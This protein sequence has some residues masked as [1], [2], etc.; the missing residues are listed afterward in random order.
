MSTVSRIAI[1]LFCLSVF[2]AAM[3]DTESEITAA[4]D[5]YAEMWNDGDIEALRGYYDPDFVLLT[6]TGTL[7]LQQRLDD[8]EA[9]AAGGKDRGEMSH[10]G[11][12]VS[13]LG[14]NHAMAYGQVRLAFKDGSS[15]EN[16]FSTVY[17][18]TP[19]GWKAMLTHQ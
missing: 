10:S 19:F 6:P 11:L 4:L 16:W 1:V 3:A 2:Q 18:K 13:P 9:L 15:I 14:S 5:Y 7:P 17:R 12:V 8:I